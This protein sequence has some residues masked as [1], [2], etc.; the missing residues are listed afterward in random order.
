MG[1]LLPLSH[2]QLL[3]QFCILITLPP[4]SLCELPTSALFFP[5]VPNLLLQVR[6]AVYERVAPHAALMTR[7]FSLVSSSPMMQEALGLSFRA[8][9]SQRVQA[10]DEWEVVFQVMVGGV[11]DGVS[12]C[13]AVD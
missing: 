11:G 3:D 1:V 8:G 9:C 6:V 12:G 2:R 7:L 4:P 13:D 10:P 5:S